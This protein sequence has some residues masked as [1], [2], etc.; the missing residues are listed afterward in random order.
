MRKIWEVGIE[1]TLSPEDLDEEDEAVGIK[2]EPVLKAEG[3]LKVTRS[4]KPAAE[5]GLLGCGSRDSG[6]EGIG[7]PREVGLY[8]SGLAESPLV[9]DVAG[10]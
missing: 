9:M 5:G 4:N 8:I 3:D 1:K 7:V 10:G 6:D 2:L